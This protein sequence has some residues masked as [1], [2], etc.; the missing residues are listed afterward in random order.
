M[1]VSQS[2][3]RPDD[4]IKLMDDTRR[5][6]MGLRTKIGRFTILAAVAL[7]AIAALPA[8]AGAVLAEKAPSCEPQP[9]SKPFAQWGDHADY[10][11]APGGSFEK[12]TPGWQLNGATVESGNESFYVGGRSHKRSL[13][14]DGGE[15]A[16]SPTICVGLEHPTIRLFARN[17]RLLLST[18][19]VEVIV[20]TSLGLKVPVPI[21]LVLPHNPWQPTPPYL[22]VANLL[23]LLP[24][25]YT[26]VAFRFRAIGLGS[27][28]IDDF[29]VDPRRRS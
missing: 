17:N 16:T 24:N 6:T 10:I 7:G 18:L 3:V 12:G 28:W 15:T 20:Q 22:V 11:L 4:E 23:P 5:R 21:G 9:T 26:P 25:N 2:A 13:K 29:Y 8:T 14:L 1:S 19:S 27:W